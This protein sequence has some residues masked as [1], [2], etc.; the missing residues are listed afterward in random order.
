MT[1]IS[2]ENGITGNYSTGI[3]VTSDNTNDVAVISGFNAAGV[4][5]EGDIMA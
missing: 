3:Y 5:I 4:N 2:L 1:C